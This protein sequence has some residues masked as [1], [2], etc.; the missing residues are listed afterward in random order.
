MKKAQELRVDQFSEQKL[1]E[2]HETILRLT[3]QVQE[4]QERTNYLNDSG[5]FQDV[6]SNHS[7]NFSQVNQQ[8]FQVR[9]LC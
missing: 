7:G 9:D 6:K 3:S 8:G 4:L 1:R 5:E 2:S